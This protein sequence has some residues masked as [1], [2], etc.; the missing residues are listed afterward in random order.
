M[1][2][3][4]IQ[5]GETLGR[6]SRAYELNHLTM[7]PAPPSELLRLS[8]EFIMVLSLFYL[9]KLFQNYFY[10]N[11]VAGI[12]LGL[13]PEMNNQGYMFLIHVIFL[14]PKYHYYYKYCSC[15]LLGNLLILS[16]FLTFTFSEQKPPPFPPQDR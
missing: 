9:V 6:C 12:V 10:A 2:A 1:S 15:Y 11:Y 5:T 14:L 4:R 13:Q 8:F 7:G 3:P 16:D